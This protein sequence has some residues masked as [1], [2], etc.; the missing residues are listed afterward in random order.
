MAFD[1][2][3]L[4]C[5]FTNGLHTVYAYHSFGYNTVTGVSIAGDVGGTSGLKAGYLNGGAG[6]FKSGVSLLRVG[7][8]I[9]AGVSR[10]ATGM[11]PATAGVSGLVVTHVDPTSIAGVTIAGTTSFGKGAA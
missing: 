4:A 3:R 8:I 7:D 9:F 2:S 5:L 1:M 11:G 6:Y 10:S